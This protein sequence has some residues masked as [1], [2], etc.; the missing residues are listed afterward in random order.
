MFIH[1]YTGKS[2]IKMDDGRF[3]PETQPSGNQWMIFLGNPP[4]EVARG[5]DLSGR[6]TSLGNVWMIYG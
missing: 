2:T 5:D 1:V 4:G 6:R 3:F